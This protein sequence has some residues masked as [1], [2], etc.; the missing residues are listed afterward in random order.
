MPSIDSFLTSYNTYLFSSSAIPNIFANRPT[1]WGITIHDASNNPA[2]TTVDSTW[3]TNTAKRKSA[4]F[5]TA[6]SAISGLYKNGVQNTNAI[7]FD[8]VPVGETW[9]VTNYIVWGVYG[10]TG[11]ETYVP[12]WYAPFSSPISL[13]QLTILMINPGELKIIQG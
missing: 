1:K 4:V 9:T 2:T 8:Y 10:S 12:L 3:W 7:T 5:I 11:S 13:N 6:W